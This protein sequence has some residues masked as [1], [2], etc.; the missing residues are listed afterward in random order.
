ME[1]EKAKNLFRSIIEFAECSN[2]LGGEGNSGEFHD[3]SEA[4]KLA[5]EAKKSKEN[6]IETFYEATGFFPIE[7]ELFYT[8][9]DRPK[10]KISYESN[11]IFPHE[12]EY[13]M[14]L[15]KFADRDSIK[16]RIV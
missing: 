16:R 1:I 9:T 4:R 6:L 2:A 14:P 7:V 13:I 11:W 10:T 8:L 12:G 15:H 3:E 5:M